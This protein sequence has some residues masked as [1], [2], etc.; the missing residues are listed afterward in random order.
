[1]ENSSAG[2]KF[3]RFLWNLEFYCTALYLIPLRP[4]LIL[5]FHQNLGLPNNIYFR[6]FITEI[7]YA[8]PVSH[9]FTPNCLT[10]VFLQVEQ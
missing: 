4:A 2:Q 8:F 9:M 3:L 5:S 6:E 10:V 7:S 1:M